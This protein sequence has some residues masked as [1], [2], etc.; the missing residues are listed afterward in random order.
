MNPQK[1]TVH[2]PLSPYRLTRRGALRRLAGT[3][4][5]LALVTT[6]SASGAAAHAQRGTPM[7]DATPASGS[8]PTI[9]LVHGAFAESASWNGVIPALLT[10]GYPVVA[11]ANPLR[12]VQTD[13]DYVAGLLAG[14]PGPIV[15]VGHSYGGAVITNAATGN[16]NVKALV[17][18]AGFALDDGESAA[19]ASGR[20][21]GSTLGETLVP[22]PLPGGGSDLYI[23]QAKFHAQFA[24]DLPAD[25]A[26]LMAATQRPATDAALNDPSGPP[27]WRAIP[28]WF[29]Y[30]E[31][32]RN[33]PA[34]VHAFMAERAGARKAVEVP[35]ASH[36]VM[37]SH[38]T[39]VADMIL[40]AAAV[41]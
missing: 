40:T 22:V 1:P 37:I 13:A 31:L 32:D 18:V 38:P 11:A 24:A 23:D 14:T 17:Y 15:L 2:P 33:I 7:T 30:G 21:P 34:A 35:G 5:A 20:F 3:G 25:E 19:V 4:A 41:G 26:A 36:V 29:I 8:T 6:G 10:Q 28:S 16:P 9:V 12:G 39:E 27:A